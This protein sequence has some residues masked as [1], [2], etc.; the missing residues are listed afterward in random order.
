MLLLTGKVGSEPIAAG[1]LSRKP[2][3]GVETV[4]IGRSI[5]PIF[6]GDPMR[7]RTPLV[8][9]T[10]LAVAAALPAHAKGTPTLDGKKTKTL[11]FKGTASPQDNDAN[12]LGDQG[13]PNPP[14]T[15]PRPDD[16]GH[17][18]AARCM[19]FPF[20]YKPAKGVKRG[21]F[22]ARIDW[23]LP[24]EDFDLYVIDTKY[25]DVGHC[26]ASAGK[27][28]YVVIDQPVPGH[29]YLIVVDEYR[30]AP[31]TVTATV[32]FPAAKISPVVPGAP[33]TVAIFPFSCGLPG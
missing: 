28:E 8:L 32:S 33:S 16:Y 30:A 11:T 15:N 10:A 17:C 1:H 3:P 5:L 24:A 20:V 21:P 29:K 9:A 2:T 7:A 19:T 14:G 4:C 12:L 26:G 22:S 23:T 6:W 31:D 25:G 13:A 27:G 18:P